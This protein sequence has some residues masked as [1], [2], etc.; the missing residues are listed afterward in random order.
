MVLHP[1]IER[2]PRPD[3][4]MDDAELLPRLCAGD[5]GAL[6]AI[7]RKSL[8]GDERFARTIVGDAAAEKVALEALLA[9]MDMRRII[10]QALAAASSQAP[11]AGGEGC[12][13]AGL[14]RDL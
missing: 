12:R 2:V 5:S 11:G 14:R 3:A 8:P 4:A 10:D 13:G 9:A 6:R 1:A 7:V